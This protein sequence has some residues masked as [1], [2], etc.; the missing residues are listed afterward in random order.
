M[1]TLF[2]EPNGAGRGSSLPRESRTTPLPPCGGK[3]L[4]SAQSSQLGLTKPAQQPLKVG[5]QQVNLQIFTD[6]TS[7]IQW[8]SS[9]S[10]GGWIRTRKRSLSPSSPYSGSWFSSAISLSSG[11]CPSPGRSSCRSTDS[12]SCW[13][14]SVM[15][16]LTTLSRQERCNKNAV[17]W[18][19][20]IVWFLLIFCL[21]LIL[22]HPW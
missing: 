5:D 17:W 22:V 19:I 13:A 12:I 10:A 4:R 14:S 21:K 6:S 7:V 9:A 3:W 20:Y 15:A 2:I 16:W 18:Y 8:P 11:S 1:H